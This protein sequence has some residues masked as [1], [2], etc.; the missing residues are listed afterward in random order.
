MQALTAPR[1]VREDPRRRAR[2]RFARRALLGAAAAL[3]GIL[4]VLGGKALFAESPEE[5]LVERF[6]REW[7]AGDYGAMHAMLTRP[8]Q[9]AVSEGELADAYSRAAETATVERIRTGDAREESGRIVLPVTATTAAFGDVAGELAVPVIDERVDWQRHLVF[10]GLRPREELDRTTE[11]PRRASILARDGTVLAEGDAGERSS[12]L[13]V[14]VTAAAGT[15]TD[16]TTPEERESL[17]ARGFPPGTPV[18]QTG[19]ERVFE[20]Q[21]AGKPGGVLLAGDREL[22]TSEPRSAEPVRTTIE[23]EVPRAAAT[24]LNGL[25]GIAV[26]DARSGEV[27]GL[28]GTPLTGPQPPGSTFKLITT[29]AALEDGKVSPS[30]EFPVQTGATIEGQTISNAH[31]EACGGT[32]RVSFA[33]SCNSV[34]APLG[35]KVG[36]KSLVDA[37]ERYGLNQ[38]ASIPSADRSTIPPAD[39]IESDLELGATA[40][41]QGD[42]LMTPIR[43]AA[44][45]QTIATGGT[46]TAPRLAP[47]APPARV[48]VTSPKV[49]QTIEDLMIG[50]VED[51]T[52]DAAAIEGVQVAGKTG[53]A[54]LGEG[55]KEHAWFTGFAPAGGK[56]G[57]P[58]R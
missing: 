53:T 12:E 43:L 20:R 16:P 24:G 51:G 4:L 2:R 26:L 56:P 41:G 49:A 30:S 19:L 48:R 14:E 5:R 31:D 50:V 7:A 29:T 28:G 58:S 17:R 55:I 44:V 21:V 47:G 27:V 6:A 42:V 1:H 8:G 18:G 11:A 3:T 35:V 45:A 52:G 10:P 46:Q 37:A 57:S 39:E 15:V 34:F 33:K 22:A 36:A 9:Q 25:G 54:E 23:P 32:F 13:G 38:P 40:I